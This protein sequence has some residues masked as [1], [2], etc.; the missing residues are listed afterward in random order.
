MGKK[1]ALLV[2]INYPG[3][4][5]ALRGCINDILAVEKLLKQ[6]FQFKDVL[7]L[8]DHAATTS[9][10][11]HALENLVKGAKP[12]DTLYFHYSGHGSQMLDDADDDHEPDGL[13]EIICPIDL[14]WDKKVIRDDDLKRVFD[15]VPSGVN[16]TVVLDCCN[17]GGGLDHMFQYRPHADKLVESAEAKK[18]RYLTP[19]KKDTVVLERK[20]GFKKKAIQRD[21]N[22]TGLLLSGCM[23]HQTSADAF[24]DGK[25]MGAATFS[26]LK[27]LEQHEYDIS[28]KELIEKMNLWLIN[29][30]FNQRPELNGPQI[31]HSKKYLSQ[32]V[33][34]SEDS[35]EEDT[36]VPIVENNP[37][38]NGQSHGETT[39]GDGKE[40]KINNKTL[41]II[42]AILAAII[43]AVWVWGSI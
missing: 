14:D 35:K 1:K 9:G 8:M 17:S 39:G 20:I 40:E 34:E 31:L 21:V 11:M 42:G 18:G 12:G 43:F 30:G 24:I 25:Y 41:S 7:L 6:Q 29:V 13:D 28:Y 22:K 10:I 26:L 23:S 37:G 4:G 36:V 15:K 38:G 16:L 27:I 2:G 33:T 19:P 32:Y 5:H 3:T